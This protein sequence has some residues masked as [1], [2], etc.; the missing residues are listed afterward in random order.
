MSDVLVF[1]V[2]LIFVAVIII[3]FYFIYENKNNTVTEN[4]VYYPSHNRHGGHHGGHH[5]DHRRHHNSGC[6]CVRQSNGGTRGFCAKCGSDGTTFGCPYG[7]DACDTDCS[8]LRYPGHK[9]PCDHCR[10]RNC[11]LEQQP[12]FEG[13]GS[14]KLSDAA[15]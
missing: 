13:F 5:G 12:V 9:K 8:K 11:D 15:F 10:D 3:T 4:T 2:S 14:D 7:Q 6:R 1:S